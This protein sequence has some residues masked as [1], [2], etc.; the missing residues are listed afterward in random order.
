[1]KKLSKKAFGNM[2]GGNGMKMYIL[3]IVIFF[4][5]VILSYANIIPGI[6]KYILIGLFALYLLRIYL[7]IHKNDEDSLD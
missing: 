2:G 5:F 6:L 4:I 7:N 1:M 3:M